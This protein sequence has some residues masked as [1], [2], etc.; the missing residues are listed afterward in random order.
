MIAGRGLAG[1]NMFPA[2]RAPD[3]ARHPQVACS[4]RRLCADFAW[5]RRGR[6]RR[7]RERSVGWRRRKGP[8]VGRDLAGTRPVRGS[9]SGAE[10]SPAPPWGSGDSGGW[11][12]IP[13]E[14]LSGAE[15]EP[16]LLSLPEPACT[17]DLPAATGPSPGG[18]RCRAPPWRLPLPRA[19]SPARRGWGSPDRGCWPDSG[20]DL[21]SRSNPVFPRRGALS[22]PGTCWPCGRR[23]HRAPGGAIPAGPGHGP[24]GRLSA[25]AAQEPPPPPGGKRGTGLA[26]GRSR[27]KGAC[28]WVGGWGGGCARVCSCPGIRPQGGRGEPLAAEHRERDPLPSRPRGGRG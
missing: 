28:G 17:G 21:V 4:G 25:R 23:E 3:P 6:R 1:A 18:C 22:S 14:S 12:L 19:V 8:G 2:R 20:P 26:S 15:M 13:A 16:V 5:P 7:R 27:G 9:G 24:R 11:N 10:P